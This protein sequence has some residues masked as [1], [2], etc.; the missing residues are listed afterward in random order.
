MIKYCSQC[1]LPSNYPHIDFDMDNICTHCREY[2]S[3]WK[4]HDFEKSEKKLKKI[5]E[6]ARSKRKKYDCLVPI[7]GGLDSS[8]TLY[9]IKEVYKLRSLAINYNNGF[10][11]ELARNN[12][13]KLIKSLNVE[14]ITISPDKKL[15]KK[16]YRIFLLSG[17]ELCTPCELGGTGAIYKTAYKENIPLIIFGTSVRT[18]GISPKEVHYFDVRYFKDVVKGKLSLSEI[19]DIFLFPGLSRMF[20]LNFI[21]R[22]KIIQLPYYLPWEENKIK[23]ILSTKFD[24]EKGNKPHADCFFFP[25]RDYIRWKNWKF[26]ARTQRLSALIRDGQ[27]SRLE[28][29]MIVNKEEGKLSD[30][31]L[32]TYLDYMGLSGSDIELVIL[33]DYRHFKTYLPLFNKIK[34]LM[35]VCARFNLLPE[36]IEKKLI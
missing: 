24:W 13:K 33:K 10:Q 16:L 27:I 7:S 30:D 9:L 8:Y 35:K 29:L 31:E 20:Y 17:A 15:L 36:N 4:R 5:L 11:T 34:W 18:E 25:V 2:D 1:I 19:D 6:N 22:I 28:A 12:I 21:K 14:L 26:G 3:K 32:N 23:D